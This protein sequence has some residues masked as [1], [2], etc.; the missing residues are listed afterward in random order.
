MKKA[1]YACCMSI[2][3]EQ[4]DRDKKL[5]HKLG[6]ELSNPPFDIAQEE[7]KKQGMAY[8]LRFVEESDAIFFRALPD[9]KIPAGVS[10]EIRWALGNGIPV[11][12]LPNSITARTMTV[13]ETRE[14]L[15]DVGY[16]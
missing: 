16:R 15:E 11:L 13:E 4:C 12:E 9:G 14:Y 1:Y 3:R 5:I 2:G 10:T 8:F 6:Y 7:Y